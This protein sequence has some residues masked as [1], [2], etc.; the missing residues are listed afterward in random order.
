MSEPTKQTDEAYITI[1]GVDLS[2]AQ[3][4]TVRVALTNFAGDLNSNGLGDDENGK[5]ITESYQ[6]RIQEIMRLIFR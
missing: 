6:K 2:L 3:S 1:N 4:T 5:A